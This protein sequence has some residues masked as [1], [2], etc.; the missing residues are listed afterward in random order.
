M[1]ETAYPDE[2]LGP[3]SSWEY[4]RQ[5]NIRGH[6]RGLWYSQNFSE[7]DRLYRA[8][9]S[10]WWP[11]EEYLHE[12]E[13]AE[14][15]S[16]VL[17]QLVAAF[18]DARL[19]EIDALF[20]RSNGA[21]PL[22]VGEYTSIK[23]HRVSKHL[24][25]LGI[26]LDP[27]QENVLALPQQH[28]LAHAR[29][30][31]G[32]TT[33][34]AALASVAIDDEKLNPNQVLILAFN[35]SAAKEIRSRVQKFESTDAYLNARTFHSLAYQLAHPPEGTEI[36]A[37]SR[38]LGFIENLMRRIWNDEF[39]DLLLQFFRRELSEIES[40][41]ADLP[42]DQYV[43][44]RRSLR[45]IT[46][47]GKR[48]KSVAEKYIAD[49]LFEHGIIYYYED[50]TYWK[51]QCAP[52]GHPYR[53]D[54]TFV[55]E[56]RRYVLEHWAIDPEDPSATLPIEW[57]TSVD[58]YRE[59]IGAKRLFWTERRRTRGTV[60]LE[61]H[62]AMSG[63]G[64]E[65]FEQALSEIL[66]GADVDFQ[67]LP[68]DVIRD[69]VLNSKSQIS[70]MTGLFLQFIQ[71]CK[72]RTW[73]VEDAGEK[74]RRL[75]LRDPK[76]QAFHQLALVMYREYAQELH[77]LNKIDFNDLLRL[78]TDHVGDV[79]GDAR[80]HLKGDESVAIGDLRW[81]LLDKYQDFTEL[82]YQM[83]QV[84]LAANPHIRVV[85]VGDDWQ[86]INSFAGS[87]LRFFK[88]FGSYFPDA[89]TASI[90]T[91]Y[92]SVGRIVDAGNRLMAAADTESVAHP[93]RADDGVV[94]AF[95]PFLENRKEPQYERARL[96]DAAYLPAIALSRDWHTDTEKRRAAAMK[97]CVEKIVESW[98]NN[99][100]ILARTNKSVY[101][102]QLQEFTRALEDHLVRVAGFD[103]HTIT[104]NVLVTTAHKA[105]G[106]EAHTVIVL[107]V[108][109]GQFPMIHP[110]NTLFEP[111]GITTAGILEDE[112]RLFYV[113]LT[114]ARDRLY[115]LVDRGDDS[116]FVAHVVSA[117]AILP[118]DQRMFPATSLGQFAREVLRRL[119]HEVTNK[120]VGEHI[121]RPFDHEEIP[122]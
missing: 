90:A 11:K 97:A 82:Y 117:K 110:D 4:S 47:D 102:V 10:E 113:A 24:E 33:T 83:L 107:D 93:N 89:G 73:S 37:D 31:S 20:N 60:F 85:A 56:G 38:Q 64:R 91:N 71:R 94:A 26:D 104:A 72:Q 114:R 101:G 19:S 92:R 87:E 105:K 53:P 42:E 119:G 108:K 28:R 111:F 81:I 86:A 75:A 65:A 36:L 100:L 118:K 55:I 9:C 29:A 41:G 120:E 18:C 61:T 16:V 39:K 76:V 40:L 23:C 49:F 34:L 43:A 58:E 22:S 25:R 52:E 1:K 88:E 77:R 69:K 8:L 12:R 98:P 106:L 96:S 78:A 15:E 63:G 46:L 99:S 35:K 121:E 57:E 115:L 51:T 5:K 59:Q 30:G 103:R 95:V 50:L 45:C 2:W 68:D 67:R 66:R 80:V 7:A 32:K 116:P 84:I 122:F 54:F 70:R 79:G 21:I 3:I 109:A 6:I 112:R 44:F 13:G 74:I 17:D 48:V 62:A 27:Q 14:R